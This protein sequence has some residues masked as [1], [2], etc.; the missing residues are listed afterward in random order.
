MT[1]AESVAGFR[2][3]LA[4]DPNVAPE[5][6]AAMT[7]QVQREPCKFCDGT[8]RV[9]DAYR[10]LCPLC[11]SQEVSQRHHE[12]SW[13]APECDYQECNECAHQWGHQ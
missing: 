6:K 8:G 7:Q 9:Q 5:F 12:T 4:A 2:A 1:P 10:G 13:L 11:E 3:M